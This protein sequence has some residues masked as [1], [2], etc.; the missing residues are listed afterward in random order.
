MNYKVEKN[1]SGTYDIWQGEN[2]IESADDY[3]YGYNAAIL[4]DLT[5]EEIENLKRAIKKALKL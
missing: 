5:L 2:Q 4:Y 3:L 1:E